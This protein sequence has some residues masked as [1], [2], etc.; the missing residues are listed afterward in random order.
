MSNY[1]FEKQSEAH[2]FRRLQL[3]EVANDPMTISMLKETEIQVG[4]KCLE[5]GAGAG[6]ILRWL[7]ERVGPSGLA[8]GVD[9]NTSF[10]QDFTSAPFQICKGTFL[11]V[12]LAQA[13]DLIHGRYILIHNK[14]D[15]EILRKMFSLLKPGGWALFEEPDFTSAT[16]MDQG[17]QN[18][19][20]RVNRAMCQ[21]FVNGGLDPAYAL[22]LP[23]KLEQTGFRVERAQSTMHLCP[24][25]SPMANVI[26]ESAL[27]LQQ[28]YCDTGLC[29]PTDVQ[30]YVR[31]SQ[32]KGYWTVY[33]S[34]TSV[35]V[36]K[37]PL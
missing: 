4:W 23:R 35:L 8:I 17:N 3:L 25:K 15:E 11:E 27:V 29:S 12:D 33:H 16:L 36:R 1:I 32:V 7:G 34:T 31:L 6:S 26:G 13:F 5:L 18:S 28:Q 24:G 30:E 20:A 2:E 9:K 37:A 10:L 22:G 14:S 19:Q 21:M